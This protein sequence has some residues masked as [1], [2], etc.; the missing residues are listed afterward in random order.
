MGA[1]GHRCIAFHPA[2]I[3]EQR[4]HPVQAELLVE[5]G[6]ADMHAACR[7]DV[8]LPVVHRTALGRQAHQRE[9]GGTAADIHDQHAL[10]SLDARLVVEGRGDRLVLEGHLAEADL[11]RSPRQGLG[12]LAVGLRIIVDEEHRPAQ[13]DLLER[14]ARRGFCPLFEGAEKQP[15]DILERHGAAQHG[16]FALQQLGAKQALERAHQSPLV[17]FEVLVQRLATVDRATLF[18][19]EEHHRGQRRL[20]T[21]QCDKRIDIRPPPADRGIGGAEIDAAGAGR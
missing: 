16:G 21:F 4:H 15:E 12:R 17:A 9:V 5:V 3:A 19:I 1:G 10:L 7:E 14:P 13:H 8:R 6:A 20:V 2:A 11:A 18:E